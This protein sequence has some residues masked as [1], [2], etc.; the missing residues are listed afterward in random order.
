MLKKHINELSSDLTFLRRKTHGVVS[1]SKGD[2]N[3][4]AGSVTRANL[5]DVDYG[6]KTQG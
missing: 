3:C 5:V 6:E 1:V 4:S 2:A